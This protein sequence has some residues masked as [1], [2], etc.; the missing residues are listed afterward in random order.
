M[1]VLVFPMHVALTCVKRTGMVLSQPHD[2]TTRCLSPMLSGRRDMWRAEAERVGHMEA[3]GHVVV[4]VVACLVM[5]L[6]VR[7][8][9]LL[10]MFRQLLLILTRHLFCRSAR[11]SLHWNLFISLALQS[12]TIK[13]KKYYYKPR[14]RLQVIYSPLF[15]L[16]KKRVHGARCSTQLFPS[17]L[18]FFSLH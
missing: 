8:P 13:A 3:S 6:T 14:V 1:V 11:R 2:Q 17:H 10:P 4:V 16:R 18:L 9:L 7:L 15:S 12:K 5:L